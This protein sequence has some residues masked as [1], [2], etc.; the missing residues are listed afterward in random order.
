[1]WKIFGKNDDS[2]NNKSRKDKKQKP[3]KPLFSREPVRKSQNVQKNTAENGNELSF[4]ERISKVKKEIDRR[5]HE[6]E[7]LHF[8]PKNENVSNKIQPEIK[9]EPDVPVKNEINKETQPYEVEISKN[10]EEVQPDVSFITQEFDAVTLD[11][12]HDI[13]D[14]LNEQ[15]AIKAAYLVSAD[16]KRF[17]E[18][19]PYAGESDALRFYA[20]FKRV[21]E[22]LSQ[23]YGSPYEYGIFELDQSLMLFFVNRN[24]KN[25]FLIFDSN[26]INLG[27]FLTVIQ[28]DLKK[29]L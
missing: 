23:N 22:N 24:E 18:I 21:F 5:I 10:H 4:E 2:G 15:G 11:K 27:Y 16:M 13:I 19:I 14:S 26:Q 20:D 1:M 25:L 12:I 9:P 3:V 28:G 6:K 8:K 17:S 7:A 29:I